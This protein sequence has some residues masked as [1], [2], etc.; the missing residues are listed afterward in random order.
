MRVFVAG[1]TGAIGRPLISTLIAAGHDVIGMT[2]SAR[3]LKTLQEYGAEGLL[4]MPW[5]GRLLHPPCRDYGLRLLSK[6]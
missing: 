3:G 1:A 5:K 4:R 2:S 6:S